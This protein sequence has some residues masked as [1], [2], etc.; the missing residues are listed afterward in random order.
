[1]SFR[2]RFGLGI[3]A[4]VFWQPGAGGRTFSLSLAGS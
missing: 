1:M 2:L 4:A 3:P